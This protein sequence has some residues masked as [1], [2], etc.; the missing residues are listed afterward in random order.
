MH[1][2]YSWL[3]SS[4]NASPIH[5]QWHLFKH[6]TAHLLIT[7]LPRRSTHIVLHLI[8]VRPSWVEP[9]SIHAESKT[10]PVYDRNPWIEITIA[11]T[12]ALAIPSICHHRRRITRLATHANHKAPLQQVVSV[13]KATVAEK[14]KVATVRTA[15][16]E[17]ATKTATTTT[18]TPPNRIGVVRSV[19]LQT[20]Q[21]TEENHPIVV[22]CQ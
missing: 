17:A 7:L 5:P 6:F 11:A 21:H 3:A 12:T 19:D 2:V 9:E 22:V 15:L 16:V 8:H 14:Q 20:V 18:T 4:I 10:T 13:T 1:K